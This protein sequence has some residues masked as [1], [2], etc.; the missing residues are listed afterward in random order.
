M[1]GTRASLRSLRLASS[2][3]LLTPLAAFGGAA[4]A[5]ATGT[6]ASAPDAQLSTLQDL[7]LRANYRQA[8]PA[9]NAYLARTDLTAGA[10]TLGLEILATVHLAM[11]DEAAAQHDLAELF[12]RDP[13]Y[14][15]SDPEASPVVQSAFARAR[16]QA[17]PWTIQLEHTA[18]QLSEHTAPIL[19]VHVAEHADAL[20]ELRLQYRRRGETTAASVVLPVDARGAAQ[21]RIPI[22]G[23]EAYRVEY[24]LS[25]VAPSGHVLGALGSADAPLVVE[26]PAAPQ[27]PVLIA[28]GDA[29]A[30]AQPVETSGGDVTSEPWFWV[31]LGVVVVGAGVGVGVGVVVAGEGPE[32]GSLGNATLPLMRF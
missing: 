28:A 21:G 2:L 16:A 3:A 12:A 23:D 24:W 14:R 17:T 1:R 9:A 8:L 30:P 13:E 29:S 25:A 22:E 26:V 18:P 19:S 32:N 11:R 5:Q 10:R 6:E 31:V 27:A 4:S 15:L 20:H 7:V